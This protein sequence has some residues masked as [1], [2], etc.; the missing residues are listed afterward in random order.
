MKTLFTTPVLWAESIVG[1]WPRFWCMTFA[2]TAS[3]VYLS[4]EIEGR[5]IGQFV[6]FGLIMPLYYL[7]A[8]RG[9]VRTLRKQS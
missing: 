4:W 6:F 8:L 1:T 7:I 9:V 5:Y 3:F 2:H